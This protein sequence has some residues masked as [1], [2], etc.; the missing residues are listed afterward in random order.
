MNHN[1]S[2]INKPSSRRGAHILRIAG[3]TFLGVCIAAGFALV[4]GL[5][6]KW[7]WNWLMP[8]LFGLGTI[9]Y[10]QA[11]G[12]VLL[13][14]LLFGSFGHRHDSHQDHFASKHEKW[15]RFF[16]AGNEAH[17]ANESESKYHRYYSRFWHEEGKR[18]FDDYI[19]KVKASETGES[20]E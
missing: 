8:S 17:E 11:F 14:K 5:V 12:I 7:L 20:K 13:A 4:F 16:G 2:P 18:A 15:H 19:R 6:V 1:T 3:W 10:L 9:T